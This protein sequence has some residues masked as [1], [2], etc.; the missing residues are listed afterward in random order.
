MNRAALNIGVFSAEILGR[1]LKQMPTKTFKAG[2]QDV[3][4]NWYHSDR[5]VDLYIWKDERAN[6]IKQQLQFH[7][8]IVE[9]NIIE[10]TRTGLVVENGTDTET[11]GETKP[12][13]RFDRVRQSYTVEQV[14]DILRAIQ[15]IADTERASLIK[16]FAESPNFG[17]LRPDQVLSL[18]GRPNNIRNRLMAWFDRVVFLFQ[19]G[20]KR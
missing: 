5:D 7:G 10:G 16:N 13:V 17:D 8:Q 12:P 19:F 6:I 15:E 4:T 3:T 11:D 20:R 14:V 2:V 18:Y 1:S 9:W